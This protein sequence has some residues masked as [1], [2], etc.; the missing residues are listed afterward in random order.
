MEIEIRKVH[1]IGGLP[2]FY[3]QEEEVKNSIKVTIMPETDGRVT[4]VKLQQV[5]QGLPFISQLDED[6][7]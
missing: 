6:D 2:H 5:E 7:G 4:Q 3:T 1:E